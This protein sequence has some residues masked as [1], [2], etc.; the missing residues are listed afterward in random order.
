MIGHR[1][2]QI[3]RQRKTNRR[4]RTKAFLALAA[5][6]AAAL[7]LV[8]ALSGCGQR[9]H[10]SVT[11]AGRI[12]RVPDGTIAEAAATFHLRPQAGDLVDVQG[13]V[14]RAG[15]FPGWLLL[16]GRR[17]SGATRLHGGD[18]VELVKGRDRTE[19]LRRQ[20][21][22]V[23]AGAPSDPQFVLARTPGVELVVRGALSHELVSAQF[24][25]SGG[26]QMLERAVALTFDDEPSLHDSLRILAV[27]RRLHVHATFFVVG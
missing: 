22:P 13:R 4:R 27:L 1:L 9:S 19:P 10:L 23:P 25:P 26:P 18:R 16:N 6:A 15:S 21:M 5:A 20:L 24:R 3:W 14:L 2:I 11:I 7:S 12:E 17:A 8:L